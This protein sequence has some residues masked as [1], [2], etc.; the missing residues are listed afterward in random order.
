[1]ILAS[2]RM[3]LFFFFF[4]NLLCSPFLPLWDLSNL[5]R[6]LHSPTLCWIK[7]C[8]LS[9]F[10][11]KLFRWMDSFKTKLLSYPSFHNQAYYLFCRVLVATAFIVLGNIF[12]V[13]FGNHQSPGTCQL[14]S[15]LCW[16]FFSKLHSKD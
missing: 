2:N 4:F 8:L 10:I 11:S 13:A 15:D 9:M 16:T 1:M 14:T 3:S 7:L 6:T 12:L 5:C